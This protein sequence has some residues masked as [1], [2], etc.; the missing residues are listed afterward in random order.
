MQATPLQNWLRG[1]LTGVSKV[2]NDYLNGNDYEGYDLGGRLAPAK[3]KAT[4]KL[5]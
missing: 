2:A 5:I 3:R 1:I 4:V